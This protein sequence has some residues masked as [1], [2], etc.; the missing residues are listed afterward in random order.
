MGADGLSGGDSARVGSVPG[1]SD[2]LT[3]VDG[4][5]R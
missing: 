4:R 5:S 3:A 1:G 2:T